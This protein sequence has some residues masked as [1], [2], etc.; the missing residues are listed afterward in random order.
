[1][2][3]DLEYAPDCE[4]VD[5]SKLKLPDKVIEKVEAKSG[6]EDETVE[7]HERCKLF[8]FYEEDKYGDEVRKNIWKE[9]GTGEVRILKHKESK[10]ERIVM[11]QEKTLKLILNHII[12]P[13]TVLRDMAGSDR[14]FTFFCEDFADGEVKPG[15]YAIRF[16]DHDTALAFKK[17]F[18]EARVCN[19]TVFGKKVDLETGKIED[20]DTKAAESASEPAPKKE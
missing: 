3:E 7:Y 2:P 9:R 14:A 16:K 20:L 13:M 10:E 11:R 12:N 8:L 15:N 19:A 4:N 18:D 17:V 1:M 5:N 6:E